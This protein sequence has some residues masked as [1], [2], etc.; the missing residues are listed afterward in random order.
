MCSMRY[1]KKRNET[2]YRLWVEDNLS[3]QQIAELE[4]YQHLSLE[5]IQNL[6]YDPRRVHTPFQKEIQHL[7]HVKFQ[8]LQNKNA[9][10]KWVYENQPSCRM[11]LR[12]IQQIIADENRRRSKLNEIQLIS[13]K[14]ICK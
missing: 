4:I 13:T 5:Y 12:T 2:I 3:Y 7:F 8:E 10:I 9:S 6:I 11:P 14:T 1:N